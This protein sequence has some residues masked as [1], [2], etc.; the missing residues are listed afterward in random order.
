MAGNLKHK[1]LD[2]KGRQLATCAPYCSLG[3]RQIP[4]TKGRWIMDTISSQSVLKKQLLCSGINV[5]DNARQYILKKGL[6]FNSNKFVHACI[7][8]FPNGSYVNTIAGE[9]FCKSSPFFL[10]EIDDQ[11]FVVNADH[12]ILRVFL[13]KTPEWY[14]KYTHDHILMSTILSVHGANTL[15]F[16]NHNSCYFKSNGEGCLFCS[17]NQ[18][19]DI[20]WEIQAKRICEVLEYALA[21]NKQYSLAL[22]G[23]TRTGEDRGAFYFSCLVDYIKRRYPTLNIS[24]ETAP[25]QKLKYLDNLIEAGV[26]SIIMNL[27]LFSQE[28]RKKY[29]PGKSKIQIEDYYAAYQ[30]VTSKLGPWQAGSVLIAGLEPIEYTIIGAKKLIDLNVR[31]TIMPFRP[32]DLSP[33]RYGKITDYTL[34]I[35]IEEELHKYINEK[36]LNICQAFGCLSCNACIANEL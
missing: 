25:P 29:C 33:L 6:Y 13:E 24:V 17:S 28:N 35:S 7:L 1:R 4:S 26:S 16:T 12:Q 9:D 23:G 22:S 2:Q 19:E 21:E 27:E 10:D 31:P 34:L 20:E 11:L 5:S 36:K 3:I 32:Y 8:R 30:L 18:S 14:G 15:A